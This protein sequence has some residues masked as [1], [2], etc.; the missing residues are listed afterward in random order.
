M[1]SVDSRDDYGRTRILLPKDEFADYKEPEKTLPRTKGHYEEF[2]MAAK[3]G[4]P[5]MT[6]SNFGYA[7]RLTETILLGNVALRAGQKIE[8]DAESMKV[9]NMDDG[10]ES[11]IRRKYREGFDIAKY[12]EA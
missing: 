11:L 3:A 2:M 7:G 4:D 6:M 1:T 8:W 10:G 12:Q 5:K 9:T